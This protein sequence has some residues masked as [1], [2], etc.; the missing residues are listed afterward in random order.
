MKLKN[1]TLAALFAL[2]FLSIG[3]QIILMRELL[4][5]CSGNE[6]V[7][8]VLLAIWMFCTALGAAINRFFQADR[9][10]AKLLL[11][12]LMISG[13]MPVMMITGALLLKEW[14]L[15][16][17]SMVGLKD[18][19]LIGLMVQ[20]PFCLLNGLLFPVLSVKVASGT[21]S[22][23]FNPF[24]R[25]YAWES[26]GSLVA[27]LLINFLL[28]WFFNPLNAIIVLTLLYYV[29]VLLY[30]NAKTTGPWFAAALV[31]VFAFGFFMYHFDLNSLVEK[32]RFPGQK[33]IKTDNTPYGNVVITLNAGQL[34]F[35]ENG[36]LHSSSGN[37]ISNEE[38]VHFPMVQHPAPRS[39]LLISGGFSGTIREA[40]KYHPFRI[41][42]LEP[43]PSLI[44]IAKT[45]TVQLRH[46]S[47]IPLVIDARRFVRLTRNRFDVAI[48]DLPEPSTLQINRFYTRQFFAELK[49]KLN[50]GGVVSLSLPTTSDYVS[51]VAGKLNSSVYNTLKM[52]FRYVVPVP[53][54]RTF[55]IA[56][57]S[58]LTIKIPEQIE[59][60]GIPTL[61][62]NH[63]YLDSDLLRSRSEQI[64]RQVSQDVPVNDDFRPVA[65]FYQLQYWMSVFP[66]GLVQTLV[67]ATIAIFLVLIS[68]NPVTVG[69]FTSGF[70]L[71]GSEVV[72][73][74]SVQVLYGYVYQMIGLLLMAFMSGLA[75][76]SMISSHHCKK[77][78][79]QQYVVVQFMIGIYSL[80]IP[81]LI[82]GLGAV[83]WPE[84]LTQGVIMGWGFTGALLVGMAY[85]IMTGIAKD[86]PKRAAASGYAA[87][88]FGSALGALIVALWLFPVM[89]L[90]ATGL[91]LSS[92]NAGGAILIWTNKRFFVNL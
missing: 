49:Q 12:L 39:V 16:M 9:L 82:F 32:R 68:L 29:P 86:T 69:M 55:F 7:L 91:I 83:N 45:F 90:T 25:A 24:S 54:D 84:T 60:K 75:A 30:A 43:D 53:V 62:V 76:G 58:L 73:L 4:I 28:L 35:Y 10:P 48:I 66:E 61:F 6:M 87:D 63:Y 74:L 38:K 70:V 88:L 5:V 79:W 89:G 15:P 50:P 72:L 67:I 57:D 92:I 78:T 64:I 31:F 85:D 36:V 71:A 41:D 33:I 14:L 56:S 80:L 46:P 52:N 34:N 2:G 37:E 44:D 22:H 26:V 23:R 3:T 21:E 81:V 65:L 77:R 19:A 59:R 20:F 27:G 13:A 42:Y 18:T 40:M 47:V 11:I 51:E 8:G 17:G 1:A